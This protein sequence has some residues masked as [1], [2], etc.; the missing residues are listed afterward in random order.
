MPADAFTALLGGGRGPTP[1]ELI[2]QVADLRR[3]LSDLRERYEEAAEIVIRDTSTIGDLQREN[4]ALR[5]DMRHLTSFYG[6]LRAEMLTAL[7]EHRMPT[8][9]GLIA[10]IE[11]GLDGPS[12]F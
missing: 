3:Q 11:H 9:P 2:H 8:D 4:L 10:A 5:T 7:A 12:P 1:R 6:K